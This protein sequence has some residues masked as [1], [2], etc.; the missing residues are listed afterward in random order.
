[1]AL[2]VMPS[3]A[4]AG[5]GAGIGAVAGAVALVSAADAKG[6]KATKQLNISITQAPITFTWTADVDDV[7]RSLHVRRRQCRG[8]VV[9]AADMD[10]ARARLRA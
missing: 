9:R 7:V 2:V 8:R 4:F 6:A 1:M 5:A 10:G 3:V